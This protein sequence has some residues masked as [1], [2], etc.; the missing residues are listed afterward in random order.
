[1]RVCVASSGLGHV[2]RGVEAWAAD[3]ASALAGR[4]VDVVLCKGGGIPNA[5]YERVLSCWQ[6]G[7]ARTQR[8]QRWLPRRVFW[9]L[10]LGTEC[11]VEQTTFAWSLLKF[12]RHQEIDILHVQDALVAMWLQ[13]ARRM[14]VVRT[15]TILAH[16]TNEPLRFQKRIT[17]LQH[18]APWH[19]EQ[20]RAA[21]VWS[22]TWT[23]IPNFV[24][25]ELFRPGRAQPLRQELGIP[26][27]A[28]VVLTVAAIKRQHKRVDWLLSEF[29][30]S[31]EGVQP[32]TPRPPYLVVAGG[33]EKDT[34]ELAE[35]GGRLL[36]E[37]ARFLVR[38]PRERMPDLY[39]AA[40]IFVL[41]SLREMMP[42]AVLEAAAS[43]LPSLVNR[44]PLLEWV[45]GPGGE[46]VDLTSPGCLAR[47]MARLLNCPADRLR[48]GQ[49]ARRHCADHFSRDRVVDQILDYYGYVLT[50]AASPSARG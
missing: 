11:E 29:A 21:G 37:R 24:D 7:A 19:L 17:Y 6:R 5:P 42:I 3:L 14:G 27:D 4:G 35:E 30:Q 40:D 18:L 25:L 33:A 43:G 49:L 28:L 1:M 38:F 26:A 45:I 16:G 50:H 34:D 20:A 10:G 12:L 41:S 15:R 2:A 32:A 46:A 31:I 44:H 36:G 8:L 39:R 47:A 13:R 22:P 9:R 23:A 48:L